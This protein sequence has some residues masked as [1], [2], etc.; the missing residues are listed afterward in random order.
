MN[1]IYL[2]EGTSILL[3]DG[4]SFSCYFFRKLCHSFSTFWFFMS[5]R[6]CHWVRKIQADCSHWRRLT[7]ELWCIFYTPCK[8]RPPEKFSSELLIQMSLLSWWGSITSWKKSNLTSTYGWPLE[9]DETSDSLASMLFVLIL[10]KRAL[11]PCQFYMSSVAVIPLP[12]S[13]DRARS[14]PGKRGSC[15]LMSLRRFSL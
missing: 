11:D 5:F 6:N 13:M 1:E 12:L 7:R 15:I 10:V 9:W 14:L 8:L 4:K 2:T 3:L